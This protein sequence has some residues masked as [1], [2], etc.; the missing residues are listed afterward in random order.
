MQMMGEGTKSYWSWARSLTSVI[1]K[2][3]SKQAIF[4]R[5]NGSWVELVKTIL[6]QVIAQQSN[7]AIIPQL[8]SSFNNVWLQDS[9]TLHLPDALRS[10]FK[11][12]VSRGKQKAVAKIQVIINVL[13]GLCPVMDI[14]S[15]TVNEQRLSP[16][17]LKIAKAG[18]LVIRD[19]GYLVLTVLKQMNEAG[20]FFF[21]SVEIQSSVV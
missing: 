4:E 14:M 9:T 3:V 15:F 6:K 8:F 7:K 17:I 11:G 16:T 19:L 13:S 5:M 21:E 12:N 20:I 1:G 2:T 10:K 18:D